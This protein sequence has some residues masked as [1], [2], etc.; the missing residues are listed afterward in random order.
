MSDQK[1]TIVLGLGNPIMSDEGVGPAL[2]Q[3]FMDKAEDYALTEFVDV[4]TGGFSLLYHLEGV[5]RVVFIDCALMGDEPGTLR[6]FTCDQVQTVKRLAH[7]SLH[8]GDL[9]TLIDKAK[10][11][12]QCPEE[13]VIFGIEPE[14]IE[15]GLGLTETLSG[16]MDEYVAQI[17]K[18]LKQCQ[19]QRSLR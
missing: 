9:L 15:F 7:F 17:D 19:Q 13:I 16:R 6:R 12:G 18:E 8:E 2:V 1:K 4:G 3:R 11:L 14:L 5:D 10:E